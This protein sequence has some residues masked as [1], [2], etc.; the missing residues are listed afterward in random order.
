[1]PEWKTDKVAPQNAGAVRGVFANPSAQQ[2]LDMAASV[3]ITITIA[4]VSSPQSAGPIAVN[5]TAAPAGSAVEAAPLVGG[6]VAGAWVPMTPGAGTAWSGSV[7]MASGTPVR[8][9]A[10][11]VEEPAQF[12]DSNA[13]TVT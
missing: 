5:G 11:A 8:I 2:W 12:V 3:P 4:T 1:M 13:F 6:V 9:R 10:R 7:T